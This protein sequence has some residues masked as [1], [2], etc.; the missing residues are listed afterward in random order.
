MQRNRPNPLLLNT[1]VPPIK[2]LNA[3]VRIAQITTAVFIYPS[4]TFKDIFEGQYLD[5]PVQQ[6]ITDYK[7]LIL[8][9]KNICSNK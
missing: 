5:F 8:N 4:I 7:T 3:S 6:F 2:G 1:E 9:R